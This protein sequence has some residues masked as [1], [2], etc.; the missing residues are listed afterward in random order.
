MLKES[1]LPSP[2]PR[3]KTDHGG[4]M[5]NFTLE[6]E[7]EGLIHFEAE[8]GGLLDISPPEADRISDLRRFSNRRSLDSRRNSTADPPTSMLRRDRLRG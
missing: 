3:W 5:D 1:L 7:P 6:T 4:L 8:P 2:F